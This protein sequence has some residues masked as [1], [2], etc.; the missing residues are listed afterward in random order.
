MLITTNVPLGATRSDQNS[1][2]F[3]VWAPRVQNVDVHILEPDER[4]VPMQ[5]CDKGYFRADLPNIPPS[6]LYRY[7]LNGKKEHPDPA[8]AFQPHGVHGPSQI[9]E[10]RFDW[11]DTGWRGLPLRDYVLYELHVGTFS[12]EGTF[13][14]IIPRIAELKALGITALE[15]MPVAQFPGDRNWG[16]D[17]VYPFA[18]QNSYGGPHGLKRLVNACHAH[19]IAAVLDVVYNHL[20]PEGNYAGEFGFYFTETYKTPWGAALNFEQEHSDEVRRYF[21][22]NA[23]RWITE[24]HMDGL[25]LDA[26][27]AIIDPS[28]RPFIQELGEACH[29]RAKELGREVQI[30]AESNR[31]DKKVVTPLDRGGW[32][33]DSQWNDD[34]HHSLRTAFTSEKE[35]YYADFVGVP[36]L[37]KAFRDGFVYDGRY[38]VFRKRRYGNSSHDLTGQ[39]LVVFSQNHDQVGNRKVG[40]RLTAVATFEQLK[41]AAAAVLL[42]PYVPLLFMGDEYGEKAP[43]QYFVSHSDPSIIEAVRKG[44]GEEFS[45]FEWAGELL[46][47]QGEKTFL[48]SKLSWESREEGEHRALLEFYR[49]LL[50]FRREI[51][52]LAKLDKKSQEVSRPADGKAIFVRRWAGSSQVALVFYF[53]SEEQLIELPLPAGVWR[54][55]V[56]STEERWKGVGGAPLKPIKSFDKAQLSLKP[57]SVLALNLSE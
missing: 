17:G 52:A 26:I 10:R 8:S 45:S 30:I 9:I 20:G 14:A 5:S 1:C 51:P 3:L 56:D 13:D 42:S 32:A 15:I 11:A 21:I 19:G 27:H 6:A 2:S 33:L 46:D 48:D 35:G 7:R 57:W 38:S 41:L 49:E 24:F 25:R 22:E 29:Q 53:G 47:P 34:F 50:R 55:I 36:D 37:E 39:N 23:L 40:D 18:V 43:F 44:R 12:A 16:Y 28:A 4:I 54:T 31:N